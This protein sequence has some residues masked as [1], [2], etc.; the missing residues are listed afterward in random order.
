MVSTEAAIILRSNGENAWFALTRDL[1]TDNLTIKAPTLEH[2]GVILLD[3]RVLD[4]GTSQSRVCWLDD[5]MHH[6]VRI[7]PGRMLEAMWKDNTYPSYA[8]SSTSW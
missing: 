7:I 4:M 3:L 1:N 2:L 8:P 5:K 6:T